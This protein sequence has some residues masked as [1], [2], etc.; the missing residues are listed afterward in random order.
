M[1]DY[2]TL[3]ALMDELL[4]LEAIQH[5]A[6]DQRDAADKIISSNINAYVNAQNAVSAEVRKLTD[7]RARRTT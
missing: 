1:S 6:R 3:E 2:T 7:L 5:A 4:R